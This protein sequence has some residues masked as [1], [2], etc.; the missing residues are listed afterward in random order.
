MV[1]SDEDDR[2]CGVMNYDRT[3][4]RSYE[5]A[6]NYAKKLAEHYGFSTRVT[7]IRKGH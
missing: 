7:L 2:V 5:S 6:L 1:I 4:G 3:N